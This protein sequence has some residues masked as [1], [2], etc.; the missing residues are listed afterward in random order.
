MRRL[1]RPFTCAG[2]VAMLGLIALSFVPANAQEPA[3]DVVIRTR[4]SFSDIALL[5]T[6]LT[7]FNA[8]DDAARATYTCCRPDQ[9]EKIAKALKANEA[10]LN[11][12]P[13]SDYADDTL[14]HNARIDQVRRNFR[15]QVQ[16]LVALAANFP[17]SDLADDAVWN[18]AQLYSR[19]K[20]HVSAVRA[21]NDLVGR[22]PFSTWVDDAYFSLARELKELNDEPGA[23]AALETLAQRF[24]KS[25]HCAQANWLL[26]QKYM[27]VGEYQAAI[28]AF[29]VLIRRYPCSDWVDDAQFN[30]AQCFRLMHDLDRAEAAYEYI[31]HRMPG[32]SFVPAAMREV[33]NICQRRHG[34]ARGT[35][36]SRY[37][38]YDL[39]A[40][41]S[42]DAA[43]ELCELGNHHLNYR[44]YRDAIAAFTELVRRYPG[45]DCYDDALYKIGV[46]YQ[47]MDMLFN[48]INKAKGPDDLF[49]LMPEYKDATRALEGIPTDRQLSSLQDAVGAFALVANNLIGSPLRDDA[50]WA[51][52]ESYEAESTIVDGFALGRT[53]REDF[54]IWANHAFTCQQLLINFPGSEHETRALWSMLKFYADKRNYDTAIQMYEQLSKCVP[55]IFP[56]IFAESKE[57]FLN[58]M[59]AYY[60]RADFAWDEYHRHHIP[61]R[62]TLPDLIPDA[63]Y[64]MAALYLKRGEPE[65]A[66]KLLLKI[67]PR[68]T[69]DLAAN[70]TLL[71]A[72]TYEVLGDT[73]KA[74]EAYQYI[75]DNHP[76]S[77]LADDAELRLSQLAVGKAADVSGYL[78][79]VGVQP[80]TWDVHVGRNVVVVAPYMVSPRL[81]AYNL[82]NIWDAA[83]GA[84][85]EWTGV[86]PQDRVVIVV[87][88]GAVKGPVTIPQNKITD[89]P[90]WQDGFY[91]MARRA[92]S[93]TRCATLAKAAP[94][95][96]EGFSRFGAASLEYSLVSETRDTIGSASAT[97][98]PHQE[99][100]EQRNRAL[101][102]L[103]EYVR[104][105]AS[106]SKLTPEVVCG[107]LYSLLD[108]HGYGKQ[109]LVDREPYRR[110]FEALNSMSQADPQTAFVAAINKTFG[111]DHSDLFKQWGFRVNKRAL[112]RMARVG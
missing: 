39:K 75:V 13:Y 14:M 31:I 68:A 89:P 41:N 32:S 64:Y 94:A 84:L 96:V 86:R 57:D 21:L 77:G 66:R 7:A 17:D 65:K 28:R 53:P 102:A 26:G 95:I 19:D 80:G 16:S 100:I 109:A 62:L 2:V 34:V 18:L 45:T 33:N 36:P 112:D 3:D 73:D 5:P 61:Y 107:M 29:T 1:P 6:R 91:Q 67:T 42:Y 20:D 46:A 58:V 82:P 59:M 88:D 90:R 70:A 85:N 105:G 60:R 40:R 81:R 49:R 104:N 48:E 8:H 12:Y 71:L 9:K 44:E 108:Q 25:D 27:S 43:K 106:L 38:R 99:V 74:R 56:K 103:Q 4:A 97:V 37:Q 72:Q 35:G 87:S 110:F 111:D 50:L 24:P 98:V 30:I 69:C 51:I 47:Q 79:Q 78:A 52:A 92:I 83:Q 101:D 23:I 93:S 10:F 55:D 22:Y 15:H 54:G 11:T 63:Q 76:L